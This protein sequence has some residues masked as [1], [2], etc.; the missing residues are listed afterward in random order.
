MKCIH[1]TSSNTDLTRRRDR[2]VGVTDDDATLVAAGLAGLAY[3]SAR[4]AGCSVS[5]TV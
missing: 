1:K 3:I 5:V 4:R 2:R